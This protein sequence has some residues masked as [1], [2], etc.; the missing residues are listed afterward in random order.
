M[1]VLGDHIYYDGGS[2]S[3]R[4][5]HGN[6]NRPGPT[7]AVLRPHFSKQICSLLT[8]ATAS[9]ANK[10]L[11]INLAASW[12][13]AGV[14]ID[15]L[16]RPATPPMDFPVFLTDERFNCSYAWGGRNAY[17]MSLPE[18]FK[19]WRL[20]I[21]D[22]DQDPLAKRKRPEWEEVDT[23]SAYQLAQVASTSHSA[24]A[25]APDIGYIFGGKEHKEDG[26][27]ENAR[28]YR[29]FNFITKESKEHEKPPYT[30]DST[31]W[32][33]QAVYVPDFGPNGLVFILGGVRSRDQAGAAYVDFQ[34]LHFMDP[35]TM[36]WYEQTATSSGKDFP[37]RRHQ[38]CAVGLPGTN[39][40]YD[41]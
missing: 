8:V 25:S 27:N 19:Y 10:T 28:F 7:L 11:M 13:S 29:S 5:T 15:E 1:A 38:H 36:K 31:L 12:D 40:T 22:D 21:E 23:T 30:T 26:S 4:G 6:P 2:V 9:T 37:H 39:G 34:N 17:N 14:R 16:D 18:P 3:Q 35:T 20:C 41:M 33:A 32:G 24:F